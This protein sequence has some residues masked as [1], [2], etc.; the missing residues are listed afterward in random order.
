MRSLSVR[1][2]IPVCIIAALASVALVTVGVGVA[3]AKGSPAKC[4]GGNIQ[5]QGAAAAQLAIEVWDTDF[6]TSTNAAAC[7]PGPSP[8][9]TFKKTSSGEGLESWGVFGKESTAHF[10]VADA[11]VATEEPPN[12]TDL[13][14]IENSGGKTA[15][16]V[17]T[18]PVAQETIAIIVHLPTGCT[19][20]TSTDAPGRLVLDNETLA[21]IWAGEEKDWGDLTDG[22][23]KLLPAECAGNSAPIIRV[24][25]KD[26]AGTTHVLKRYLG[27]F[28]TT[29]FATT[30][31]GATGVTWSELSEGAIENLNWPTPVGDQKVQV[32]ISKGDS[33]EV[34]EVANTAGSIGYAGLADSRA[35]K[36]FQPG[37]GG[38]G[39][40]TFWVEVQNTGTSL[41][42][43]QAWAD[44]SVDKEESKT[45]TQANCAKEKYTNGLKTF[46]P[47]S[48]LEPWSSATTESKEKNYTLCTFV[49]LLALNKYSL[50]SNL[51][52]TTTAGEA[53]TLNQYL[54]Y[55]LETKG[56]GT[57]AG[58]Q[59]AVNLGHDYEELPKSI[60]KEA[61][62]GAKEVAY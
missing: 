47:A 27:V 28:D 2:L 51:N 19:S 30:E 10:G 61:L 35:N 45:A 44:P 41:T 1:R 20:A 17:E 40:A 58:G 57:S 18:I 33:A 16:T 50:Y 29:P 9:V 54:Q 42:K 4:S 34:T 38:A 24:V 6:N 56:S 37:T 3:S 55:A 15:N 13:T 7:P 59:V 32:E 43:K 21:K 5:G 39:S 52:E 60:D 14:E 25:R 36:L 8:A 49:Y 48:T 53:E 12:A 62:I 46:P 11:F 26:I 23:D 22:G 31:N